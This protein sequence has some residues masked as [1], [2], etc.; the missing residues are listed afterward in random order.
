[1][2]DVVLPITGTEVSALG[3]IV[4]GLIVGFLAGFFGVGGGFLMTPMLNVIF[5][6]PYNIAVGTDL[7]QM[8]G[9]STSATMRHWKLGNVDFKLGALMIMGTVMGVEIGAGIIEVLKNMG[10]LV[11]NNQKIP[12]INFYVSIVYIVLLLSIGT[13]ILKESIRARKRAADGHDTS[14]VESG[15]AKKVQSYNIPPMISLPKSGIAK[16]SVWVI[17]GIG[18]ATGVLAGFMGVGGGF[19]RMP[20]F[21]YVMGIP[22]TTAIGTDLFEIVFSGGYGALTHTLKGNVD[23]LLAAILLIGTTVGAQIG[24]LTTRKVKGAQVRYYFS[25]IAYIAVVFVIAKLLIKLGYI[26]GGGVI[27]TGGG[28]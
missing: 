9:T 13:L 21:I 22:T 3:L 24:A 23:V 16:I 10:D 2:L 6:I 7:A 25:L 27:E 19:I 11:I 8:F 1:M 28:H 5:N 17:L 12:A 18:F 14:K 4:L 26:G 15:L 20:A